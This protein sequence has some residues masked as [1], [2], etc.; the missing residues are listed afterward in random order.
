[1]NQEVQV[2]REEIN[3]KEALVQR[4]LKD[5]TIYNKIQV[6]LAKRFLEKGKLNESKTNWVF[7]YSPEFR[8]AMIEI[9]SEEDDFMK[10]YQEAMDKILDEVEKRIDLLHTLEIKVI[11]HFEGKDVN[12]DDFISWHEKYAQSFLKIIH[13][14]PDILKEFESSQDVEPAE[15]ER[16]LEQIETKLYK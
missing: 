12:L 6:E 14:E 11:K 2:E 7:F 15:Q 9:V 4:V 1:M 3:N 8:E 10:T 13:S 16:L 5:L